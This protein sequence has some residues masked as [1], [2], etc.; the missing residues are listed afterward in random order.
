MVEIRPY[1]DGRDR[2]PFEDWLGE[3]DEIASRRIYAALWRIRHG[4]FSNVKG[5]GGGL[6]EYRLHFGP[7]YRIYFGRDGQELVILLAGGIKDRQHRDIRQ[8]RAM[9]RD[10]K[11]R[12]RSKGG[13][14]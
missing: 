3:L 13:M 7:G 12:K 14:T 5:L 6:L 2:Q 11:N 4:N 8:A 9:W 1:T 10:Y